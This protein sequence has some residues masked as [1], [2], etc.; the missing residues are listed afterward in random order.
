MT[1]RQHRRFGARANGS[2]P[3]AA[4][5]FALPALFALLAASGCTDRGALPTLPEVSVDP[6]EWQRIYPAVTGQSLNAAWGMD[7]DDMWAVGN[8][9]AIIH[10]DGQQVS[11]FEA[12]TGN[13]LVAI[14]GL[15][16]DDI[17]AVTRSGDVLRWDGRRWLLKHPVRS[18]S[19]GSPSVYSV[20]CM[21]PDQ[22]YV[23]GY[24]WASDMTPTIWRGDGNEWTIMPFADPVLGEPIRR[25][26]QPGPGYPVL[27]AST[28]VLYRCDD[29]VWQVQTPMPRILHAAAEWILAQDPDDPHSRTALFRLSPAGTVVKEC[30]G[31]A[32]E[33]TEWIALTDPPLLGYSYSSSRIRR[34]VGCLSIDSQ[35]CP[36][37]I[38][39]LVSPRFPNANNRHGF[40]VGGRGGFARVDFAA[41]D[42]ISITELYPRAENR[43]AV[44]VEGDGDDLFLLDD[45]YQLYRQDGATW[46]FLETPF[47]AHSFRCLDDG[48]LAIVQLEAFT[49]FAAREPNGPWRELPA[50]EHYV[51]TDRW[52]IDGSLRPRILTR[53]STTDR[54]ELWGL[55][56]ASWIRLSDL[57]ED[58]EEDIGSPRRLVGFAPDDLYLL[59]TIQSPYAHALL[60]FD[61]HRVS[62]VLAT[63]DVNL[64]AIAAGRFS[65]RLYLRGYRDISG[66]FCGYLHEGV[67]TYLSGPPSWDNLCEVDAE[68]AYCYTSSQI[69]QLSPA[70]WAAVPSLALGSIRDLWAQADQGLFVID[71]RGE[72]YHRSLPGW[73]K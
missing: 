43:L 47:Y 59:V 36:F 53:N 38:A 69:Y 6:S 34:L 9:G 16:R 35:F 23:G 19:G 62:R 4:G 11:R 63:N 1:A 41:D 64:T 73:T 50:L 56:D 30:N 40:A 26:W 20:W 60:H 45:Q 51:G 48:S 10:F 21:V 39:D 70:G 15:A 66:D 44:H 46:Q 3:R 42:Y 14:H 13:D 33:Y 54:F 22:I 71:D 65:H 28:Y 72:I 31:N 52:W 5:R 32:L 68:L 24:L 18:E 37:W 2:H 58:I 17:W 55:E 8:R 7:A 25:I 29:D 12:E 49:R 67:L 57:A 61:G 27:A